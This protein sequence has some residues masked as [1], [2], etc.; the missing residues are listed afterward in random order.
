MWVIDVHGYGVTQAERLSDIDVMVCDYVGCMDDVD[1]AHVRVET[2]I[3]MPAE[4]REARRATAEAARATTEA[5]TKTR[6]A[7]RALK[8]SG[9][10]NKEIAVVLGVTE[11]RISQLTRDPAKPPAR[12]VRKPSRAVG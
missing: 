10:Q 4:V 2:V 12:G 5:A 6:A 9:W 3:E 11:G 1:P 7:V 8:A